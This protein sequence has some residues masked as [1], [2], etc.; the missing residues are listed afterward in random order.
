MCS[1]CVLR[2][3]LRQFVILLKFIRA[4]FF[5]LGYKFFMLLLLDRFS[6]VFITVKYIKS[7]AA[8]KYPN[9]FKY[10]FELESNGKC[11]SLAEECVCVCVCLCSG[12]LLN[13]AANCRLRKVTEINVGK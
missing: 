7:S 5:R 12:S 8:A 4:L 2:Q 13:S 1:C 3:N 9:F 10:N 11:E 6:Y